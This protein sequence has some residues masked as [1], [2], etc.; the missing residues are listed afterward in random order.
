MRF[1]YLHPRNQLITIMQRIYGYGMTTTSGGNLSILDTNGDLWI[2]PAGIDKGALVPND[3]VCVKPD[4]TVVGPHRPSSEY[5][6]H[7]AIYDQRPDFRAIVHAHPAA[8]VA[9]SI[10]R[11][12]PETRIIPQAHYV[13]GTV[14]YAPYAL[15]GSDLLGERIAETFAQGYDAVLLEN[16]GVVA[17]GV[18]LL[19]A[20][21][22]FETLDFC[23]RTLIQARTVGEVRLLTDEEIKRSHSRE[24]LSKFVREP[25][26]SASASCA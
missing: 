23:A 22:R 1:E 10:V 6:F 4:G 9:F 20:F 11:K 18:D 12:I 3:I 14:G 17:G 8:L 5:P 16:H 2:T 24:K 15:P 7:R 21:Q 26:S 13:C 19:A 25:A